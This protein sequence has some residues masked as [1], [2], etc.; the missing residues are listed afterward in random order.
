MRSVTNIF[1]T[2]ALLAATNALARAGDSTRHYVIVD[3]VVSTSFPPEDVFLFVERLNGTIERVIA[4]AVPPGGDENRASEGG[5]WLVGS[6]VP[7]SSASEEF[8]FSIVL[9]GRGDQYLFVPPVAWNFKE[10]RGFSGSLDLLDEHL[11]KRRQ[12]LESWDLQID[13]QEQSLRRLRADAE[14]IADLGKIV[15]VREA[16]AQTEQDIV[17]LRR[18]IEGLNESLRLARSFPKPRN[19]SVREAQLTRGISDLASIARTAEN[20]EVNRRAANESDLQRKISIIES[21][22]F[23]SVP[24][25]KRTLERVKGELRR[26]EQRIGTQAR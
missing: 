5:E 26:L 25:L 1:L 14:I 10:G 23:D 3:Q 17:A 8:S 16:K 19:L 18:D 13:T 4:V 15:E 12:V 9:I 6:K 22:R 11:A 21:T 20:T 7:V 2:V 24:T